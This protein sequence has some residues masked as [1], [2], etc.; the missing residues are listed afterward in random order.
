LLS[1]DERER[2]ARFIFERDRRRYLVAHI[3]L[4]EILSRY[5]PIEPAHLSFDLGPNGKP[6]LHQA[7]TPSGI[8]FNLSH[9]NEMALLAVAHGQEVG[10]DV[11]YVR[12][13]FEF[14]EV[15]ER[16]FT[17]KEVAAMQSLPSTL[18][19]QAFFKC[20]TSKEAFL[21]AKGTGLSGALD[22]VE[23]ALGGD[24]RVRVAANVPNWWLFELA[25]IAGYEAALVITNAPAPI[26]CYQWQPRLPP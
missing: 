21:K 3:A 1:P 6:K 8:E 12:E 23:I 18:Q 24:E 5:L 13:K 14:Q 4:H 10:V 22:E 16:F 19:R 17:A 9:S 2:A 11:E 25:P 7:L 15:A 20:W 26:R